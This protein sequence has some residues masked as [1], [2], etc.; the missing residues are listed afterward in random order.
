MDSKRDLVVLEVSHVQPQCL[1][2]VATPGELPRRLM[3]KPRATP[4]IAQIPMPNPSNTAGRTAEDLATAAEAPGR[5]PSVAETSSGHEA[6]AAPPG[7][8]S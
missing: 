5:L 8:A 2:P 1:F 3:P 4:T 7:R 6:E